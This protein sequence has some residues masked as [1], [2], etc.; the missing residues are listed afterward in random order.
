[1]KEKKEKCRN[2][3]QR[4]V[5]ANESPRPLRPRR[6]MD[7]SFV[8]ASSLEDVK[9]ANRPKGILEIGGVVID[10]VYV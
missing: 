7:M 6:L 4:T 9:R 5:L 1:M 10:V 2:L 3:E 8:F